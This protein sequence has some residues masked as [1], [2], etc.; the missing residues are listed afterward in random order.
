[1]PDTYLRQ[2][3]QTLNLG[4][5]K[6]VRDLFPENQLKIA[7]SVPQGIFCKLEDSLLSEREVKQIEIKLNEWVMNN[8]PIEFLVKKK[9]YYKY[10]VGDTILKSIYPANA[11]TN[12]I[13][14][15][16]IIPF[17]GG[18]IVEFDDL[19]GVQKAPLVIP[20]KLSATYDKTQKWLHNIKIEYLS[21]VNEYIESGRSDELIGIA[22][23]LQEKEISDIADII[24]QQKRLVRGLLISGPSSS[25]KTSFA[26]RISTQLRVNGLKPRPLSLDNYYLNRDQVPR[27]EDG[28]YDFECLDALDVALLQDHIFRL[29]TGET[30]ETPIFDFTKGCRS[31]RSIPMHLGESELLVIEGIHALNP[32]LLPAIDRNLFFRLYISALFELNVDLVNRI[33]TTEV[34]LIRRLVRDDRFRGT[35]A[36]DTF[37]RW[38]SVRKG[39][40]NYIFKHQ[41]EADMMF[42]SS[43]IYELNALRTFAEASLEKMPEN[44]P[45]MLARERLLNIL[46]FVK[47]MDTSKVPFNSILREFIGGSIYF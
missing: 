6:V 35:G 34:R 42:N 27:D 4:I 11:L 31:E 36:Q 21:D 19:D 18:F 28:K 16:K 13:G 37:D 3:R 40:Y 33:P 45:Y 29:I 24:L 44:S 10:E 41:E 26:Q 7:Y 38:A 23:A 25:G 46:S 47:P 39:E 20:E 14:P 8:S 32:N 22:E 15:F 43:L 5:V 1:M 2:S 12:M 17:S 30:V 9:G